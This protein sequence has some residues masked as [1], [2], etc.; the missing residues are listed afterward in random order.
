MR[1]SK[2]WPRD[3]GLTLKPW[4]CAPS[5]NSLK[6]SWVS[7][8]EL[9]RRKSQSGLNTHSSTVCSKSQSALAQNRVAANRH[10]G[11]TKLAGSRFHD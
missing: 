8:A 11:N 10:N 2:M 9:S 3:E 4:L 6:M 7:V 1:F 5:W